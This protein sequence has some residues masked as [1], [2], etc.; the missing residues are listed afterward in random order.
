MIASGFYRLS[1]LASLRVERTL[2]VVFDSI[3]TDDRIADSFSL[4][5]YKLLTAQG[6]AEPSDFSHRM[7][8]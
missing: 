5:R 1:K 2:T 6:A 4:K 8:S 3:Y 7:T